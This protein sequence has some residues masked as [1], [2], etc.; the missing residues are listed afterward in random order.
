MSDA[1]T[2]DDVLREFGLES[3]GEEQ[4][5]VDAINKL[6]DAYR[7]IKS[8]NICCAMLCAC[9]NAHDTRLATLDAERAGVVELKEWRV[10]TRDGKSVNAISYTVERSAQI[11][12]HG[13]DSVFPADAPH[14]VMR[15]CLTPTTPEASDGE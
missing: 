13:Y 4:W 15:V 8:G 11:D 9:W 1:R 10:V 6:A 3:V 7:Q 14:R 2:V 12:C 5:Q